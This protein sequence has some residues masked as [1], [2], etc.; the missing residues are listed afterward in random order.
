MLVLSW[1]R[2]GIRIWPDIFPVGRQAVRKMWRNR[3]MPELCDRRD[4]RLVPRRFAGRGTGKVAIGRHRHPIR[5][6]RCTPLWNL[7]AQLRRSIGIV[8]IL[9]IGELFHGIGNVFFVISHERSQ[10]IGWQFHLSPLQ[11]VK[12]DRDLEYG[13]ENVQNLPENRFVAKIRDH[14]LRSCP[15]MED[16]KWAPE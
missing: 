1:N 5:G 11:V 16:P 7:L 12:E 2:I 3:Q 9:N 4:S 13:K 14:S 6:R 8:V 10:L 15:C